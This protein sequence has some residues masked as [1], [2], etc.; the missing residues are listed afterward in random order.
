MDIRLASIYQFSILCVFP[1]SPPSWLSGKTST[2]VI[3]TKSLPPGTGIPAARDDGLEL[4]DLAASQCFPPVEDEHTWSQPE[5][6]LFIGHRTQGCLVILRR[7]WVC[8]WICLRPDLG[9]DRGCI[10]LLP[11]LAK[12]H[13]ALCKRNLGNGPGSSVLCLTCR[14]TCYLCLPSRHRLLCGMSRFRAS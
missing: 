14:N 3:T 12:Y 5:L 9:M 1:V 13:K 2:Q 8:W 4:I 7:K 11:H 6:L 10:N